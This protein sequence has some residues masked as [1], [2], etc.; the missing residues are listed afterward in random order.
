MKLAVSN[1]AWT[2]QEDEKVYAIMR[3]YGYEGLEIAPTRFFETNPYENLD[4]V[5][6]WRE[7]FA[8]EEGFAIP[9]MQSVWF[10]RTEKL[11]ADEAQRQTLLAY[12]KKAVDF[13][14]AVCCANLV[15]GSPKNR[16][17]PD[18]SDWELWQQGIR[19]FRAAGDYALSKKTAV[20]MEANPAIYNTNYINTT[21]EAL[22]LIKQVGSGGFLLNLDTGTM[23]ENREP[24]EVLEGNA[25][26][27][28]HVHI[29]EPFLKPVGMNADRRQFHGELAAFLR[30]NGY[31]GYV[32]VEMGKAG[33]EPGRLSVIDEILAYGREMFG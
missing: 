26:L 5:R 19:F 7:A 15:F 32:S 25:G 23:I 1:I 13:A 10:G 27:I 22:D 8:R 4:A 16:A 17:I 33:D 12:T 18:A 2:A 11:F 24:V 9:S 29:S 21:Q 28:H 31:Q 20:G 6:R 3:K 30:E 14:E